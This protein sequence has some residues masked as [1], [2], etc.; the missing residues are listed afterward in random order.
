MNW[1]NIL[2]KNKDKNKNRL[3][4]R[5]F[6]STLDG[7]VYYIEKMEHGLNH[8]PEPRLLKPVIHNGVRLLFVNG[9]RLVLRENENVKE[10]FHDLLS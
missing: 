4:E 1:S 10:V 5:R 7:R 2:K 9:T 3:T 8:I 6:V